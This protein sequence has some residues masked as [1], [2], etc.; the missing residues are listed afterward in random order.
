[1]SLSIQEARELMIQE[2]VVVGAYNYM[3]EQAQDF[4]DARTITKRSE[5]DQIMFRKANLCDYYRSRHNDTKLSD[6]E[7]IDKIQKLDKKY[8]EGKKDGLI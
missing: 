1:M 5:E 2:T 4:F 6:D 8:E 3:L 7:I